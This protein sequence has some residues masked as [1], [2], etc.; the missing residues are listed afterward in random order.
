MKVTSKKS[1]RYCKKVFPLIRQTRL[2]FCNT[3]CTFVDFITALRK[4]N[5]ASAVYA[6]AYPSVGLSVRH[7]PVFL[8]NEVTQRDAIFTVT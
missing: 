1:L 7:T 5:F 6:T 4:V 3:Q 2:E 8:S